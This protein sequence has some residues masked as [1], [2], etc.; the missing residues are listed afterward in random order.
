MEPFLGFFWGRKQEAGSWSL[1]WPQ[2]PTEN[3]QG[4]LGMCKENIQGTEQLWRNT[5]TKQEKSF[6]CCSHIYLVLEEASLL[7]TV[8]STLMWKLTKEIEPNKDERT[9]LFKKVIS[10][11]CLISLVA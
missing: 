10:K 8:I 6:V 1:P 3:M 2:D 5:E 9:A 7:S 11:G 4:Q